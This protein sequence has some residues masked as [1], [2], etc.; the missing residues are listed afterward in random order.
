MAANICH[1]SKQCI[2]KLACLAGRNIQWNDYHI[3]CA[4]VT[5]LYPSIPIN[6][7]LARTRLF[8]NKTNSFDRSR[9]AFI[10]DLLEWVL[11]NNYFSFNRIV[12]RQKDG[13]A[14]GTPVAVAYAQIVLTQHDYVIN[15]QLKPLLYYRYIDD[16][17]L[18]VRR[19]F[20]AQNVQ[21][22]FTNACAHIKVESLTEGSDGIFLDIVINITSESALT[23]AL[24]QK[25]INNYLYIPPISAHPKHMLSNFMRN[26]V[27][28][29]K[30]HCLK[31]MD[32]DIN[33]S[34]FRERLYNRGYRKSFINESIDKVICNYRGISEL[35]LHPTQPTSNT[36]IPNSVNEVNINS[37]HLMSK[38]HS[39]TY[40][41]TP[42]VITLSLPRLTTK[43]LWKDFFNIPENLTST[44]EYVK[45]FG[46]RNTIIGRRLGRKLVSFFLHPKHSSE[47]PL[48]LYD[49]QKGLSDPVSGTPTLSNNNEHK[50]REH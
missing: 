15:R 5:S 47:S 39:S 44:R 36:Q 45:A 25:T 17:F 9:I 37:N 20:S 43:V 16:L 26:E 23:Y 2:T 13:T 10:I 4:D 33:I 48:Q 46:S 19:D 8:L 11:K 3:I 41:L 7:G 1:S 38:K 12:Y 21:D 49:D 42:P 30:D 50:N 40:V 6:F 34:L 24:Y 14:M 31:K 28:R 27:K 18:I 22:I 29:I 32:A 35:L